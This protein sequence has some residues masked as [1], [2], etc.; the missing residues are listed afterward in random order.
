MDLEGKSQVQSWGIGSGSKPKYMALVPKSGL[1][2]SPTEKE[3]NW[4]AFW[5]V[6]VGVWRPP[7]ARRS[8]EP[9]RCSLSVGPEL[10]LLALVSLRMY[11][12][13]SSSPGVKLLWLA[14]SC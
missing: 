12:I 13:T 2:Q 5:V 9:G 11:H 7:R 8:Q 4:G 10:A 6:W 1:D 3:G 14:L